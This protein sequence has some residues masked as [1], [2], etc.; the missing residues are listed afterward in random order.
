MLPPASAD[1]LAAWRTS[2]YQRQYL[3]YIWIKAH[4]LE[5]TFHLVGEVSFFN[6]EQPNAE[7]V[8]RLK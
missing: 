7:V 6:R 5:G 3:N 1:I 2:P 8:L 4:H